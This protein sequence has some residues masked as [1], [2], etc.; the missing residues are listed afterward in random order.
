MNYME[1]HVLQF[2]RKPSHTHELQI[3]QEINKSF[4]DLANCAIMYA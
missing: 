1:I 2:L 3:F 4:L